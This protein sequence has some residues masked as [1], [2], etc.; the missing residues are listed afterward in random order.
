MKKKI[1]AYLLALTMVAASA[2]CSQAPAS[3]AEPGSTASSGETS[4][5][6]QPREEY[7]IDVLLPEVQNLLSTDTPVGNEL[8]E[9]F[10]IVFNI[11][12]YAGDYDEQVALMLSSNSYPEI[13]RL[14][15]A[16]D[17]QKYVKAGAL[18]DLEELANSCGATI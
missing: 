16:E 15:F 12:A 4:S 6:E 7:V 5:Q 14:R 3:S 8:K 11:M 17:I 10:N 2:G 9:R 18:V 1:L 13:V